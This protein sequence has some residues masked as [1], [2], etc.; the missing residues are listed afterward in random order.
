MKVWSG[1]LDIPQRGDLEDH[2]VRIL[3]G[4]LIEPQI[5]LIRPRLHQAE[6]LILRATDIGTVVARLAAVCGERVE[7]RFFR[8]RQR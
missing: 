3:L 4:P 6:L 1:L 5:G 8:V 2:F 7:A